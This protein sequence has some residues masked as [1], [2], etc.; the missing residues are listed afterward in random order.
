[1]K[2][3]TEA[4]SRTP[5]FTAT[6]AGRKRKVSAVSARMLR[7][8]IA[9]CP[10]ASSSMARPM[11]PNPALL[12]RKRGVRP[13]SPK[14]SESKSTAPSVVRSSSM[15]SGRRPIGGD[16]VG[17][18]FQPVAA[19]G[20]ERKFTAVGGE[21]AGKRRANAVGRAGDD[22]DG[23]R[24]WP[25]SLPGDQGPLRAGAAASR[26]S[27]R[28]STRSRVET[29]SNSATRQ[30]TFSSNSCTAPSACAM[31]QSMPMIWRRPSS[32]SR[33]FRTLVKR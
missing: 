22:R 17:Q 3:A 12:T 28:S 18:S 32:S 14:R 10:A 5:P 26:N 25:P 8:T 19:T 23:A 4:T 29:P 9:S 15:G 16:F 30:T 7:S 24:H 13:A 11:R 2:A 27:R 6:I 21:D 20:D 33:R 31:S 1:M